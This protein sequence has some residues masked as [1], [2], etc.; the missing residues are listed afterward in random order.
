M[1][2]KIFSYGKPDTTA[3]LNWTMNMGEEAENYYK[4]ATGYNKA[5]NVLARHLLI[6]NQDKNM[7]QEIFP[8]LFLYEQAVELYLKSILI[9]LYKLCG[10]QDKEKIGKE[11]VTHDL[12]K[13]INLF[14]Q[15]ADQ[16]SE[17]ND[18]R[19]KLQ[20]LK[21]YIDERIEKAKGK[22]TNEVFLTMRYPAD[23]A[24]KGFLYKNKRKC[25]NRY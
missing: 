14:Y 10:E 19:K 21:N 13:L 18:N 3:L 20:Q 4:M 12:L 24:L 2:K 6:D 23:I 15:K 25:S 11:L 8:L 22:N 1:S 5:A 16:F 7:D 9:N 17:N